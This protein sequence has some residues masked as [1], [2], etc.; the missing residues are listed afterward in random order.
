MGSNN[1]SKADLHSHTRYSG[2]GKLGHLPFP[3]SV[4]KPEDI[5]LQARK[6]G[7]NVL[8]VTDHN[9]TKGA[10]LAEK[11]ARKIKGIDVIIGEEV[12]TRDGEVLALFINETIPRDLTAEET[13][14]KIHE[15]GGLAIV[16]HP[17]SPQC[18]C[19][20]KKALS[21]NVDGVELFNSVHRDGYSNLLAQ[22]IFHK[23]GVAKVGG[24]D[25]HTLNM[26]GN[27]YTKFPGQGKDD[28]YKA[29]KKKQTIYG[30]KLTPVKE[31]LEWSGSVSKEAISMLLPA[32]KVRNPTDDKLIEMGIDVQDPWSII[33]RM[34]TRNKLMY[35]FGCYMYLSPGIP[36]TSSSI[37]ER[38][39]RKKGR[40]TWKSLNQDHYLP[41]LRNVKLPSSTLWSLLFPE[42]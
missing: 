20:G 19:L 40:A 37:G 2:F 11:S 22:L 14:E 9:E 24:S 18:H 35:L 36:V 26:V 38:R 8:A 12:S 23:E 34:K 42:D 16:A 39:L 31:W 6:K 33:Y 25:A 10:L 30:G 17:F 4:T 15:Q 41:D 1:V 5:V 7:M 21:L 28:L 29:I 13:I 32:F 3:E 27:G